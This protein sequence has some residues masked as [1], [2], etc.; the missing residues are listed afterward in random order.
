[1][2]PIRFLSQQDVVELL[3]DDR[4]PDQITIGRGSPEA[5]IAEFDNEWQ[6]RLLTLDQAARDIAY[7]EA[8]SREPFFWMPESEWAFLKP[9]EILLSAPTRY[10]LADKITTF[11][12]RW[13]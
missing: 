5:I 7:K 2:A 1:M 6:L 4:V 9:G 10:A 13:L 11:E 12:W 3:K 8:Q